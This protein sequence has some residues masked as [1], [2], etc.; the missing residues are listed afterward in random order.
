MVDMPLDK[1]GSLDPPFGLSADQNIPHGNGNIDRAQRPRL[2][3]QG[4]DFIPECTAPE[5]IML[6]DDEPRPDIAEYGIE[7]FAALPPVIRAGRQAP[8]VDQ[9]TERFVG[10]AQHGKRVECGV[11]RPRLRNGCAAAGD[12]RRVAVGGSASGKRGGSRE[13]ADA[14]QMLHPEQD[15]RR[16]FSRHN[17]TAVR[18]RRGEY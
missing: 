7:L 14:E 1:F 6:E 8:F 3:Q 18:C 10:G 4:R 9:A 13:M 11:A 2:V 12:M 16:R 15:R 5:R 17:R